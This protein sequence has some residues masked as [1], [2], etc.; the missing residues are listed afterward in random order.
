MAYHRFAVLT[1]Q[2]ESG[3]NS[4]EFAALLA[5]DVVF[6]G[7]F[8][9]KSLRGNKEVTQRLLSDVYTIP[10]NIKYTHQ[11]EDNQGS[12]L[13]LWEATFTGPDGRDFPLEGSIVIT[14]GEDGLIHEVTN[15]LRPL[16]VGGLLKEKMVKSIASVLPREYYDPTATGAN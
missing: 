16:Q 2:G 1:E 4:P 9:M 7:P 12:T 13:F 8:L 14:E 10:A 15:Y 5:S 3:I 6:N 11:L